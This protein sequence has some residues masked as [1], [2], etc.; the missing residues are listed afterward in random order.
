MTK[1]HDKDPREV[2]DETATSIRKLILQLDN[3]ETGGSPVTATDIQTIA[4]QL[5][6]HVEDLLAASKRL[7]DK[8]E[9]DT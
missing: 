5:Q 9:P 3:R 8:K 6:V 2:L 4:K 7:R 1:T